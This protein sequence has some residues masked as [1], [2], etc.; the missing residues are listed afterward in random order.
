MTIPEASGKWAR[1]FPE[2]F[3][4]VLI[5]DGYSGYNKVQGAARA[6]CWAHMRRKWLEATPEGA[7]AKICKAAQGYAF[8]SRLFDPDGVMR[9]PNGKAFHFCYARKY[10]I[11]PQALNRHHPAKKQDYYMH[12]YMHCETAVLHVCLRLHLLKRTAQPPGCSSGCAGSTANSFS[13]S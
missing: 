4:G 12:N 5:T 7:D 13:S 3:S 6:G 1:N 10:T 11:H 2:G 8:C 9:C